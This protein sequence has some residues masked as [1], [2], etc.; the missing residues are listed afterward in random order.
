[1]N[2]LFKYCVEYIC[3]N[4]SDIMLDLNIKDKFISNIS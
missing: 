3:Y 2:F 4:I 1:M